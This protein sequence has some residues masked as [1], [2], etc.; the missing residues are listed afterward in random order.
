MQFYLL[1]EAQ[2]LS[3]VVQ[4]TLLHGLNLLLLLLLSLS[5]LLGRLGLLG[6]LLLCS[7]SGLGGDNGSL[8]DR[9]CLGGS[10]NSRGRDASGRG[11]NLRLGLL[12]DLDVLLFLGHFE[13]FWG[14]SNEIGYH[15]KQ[16]RWY[17]KGK[18]KGS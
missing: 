2:A 14:V 4:V 10:L 17:K 7:G 6:G 9:L 15:S 16:R 8:F 12:R 13:R 5:S 11:S 3:L 1:G 18:K